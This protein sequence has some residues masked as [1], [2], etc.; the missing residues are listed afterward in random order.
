MNA[1]LPLPPTLAATGFTIASARSLGIGEKRLRGRDLQAPFWGVRSL[2]SEATPRSLAQAYAVRMPIG[3]FFSHVTAAELHGIPL[4]RSLEARLAVDVS[5]TVGRAMPTGRRVIGHRLHIDPRDLVLVDGMPVTSRARTWCDL[6][7]ALP[8]EDLIAAGDFLLWWR[9]PPPIYL[10]ASE[11]VEMVE[12][13]PGRRSHGVLTECVMS[14]SDRADSPPE[15]KMRRRFCL[16]GAPEPDVNIPV[17]DDTG[18]FVGQPDLS[19][20]RYRVAFDY[21]GDHHRANRVQWGKDL[22]RAPRFEDAAWSYLR[23]GAPDLTDS[24]RIISL[25]FRRLSSGGYRR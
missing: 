7:T 2:G 3:R 23:A 18:A 13:H 10:N 15:S 8:A 9:H 21:E 19:Y 24:R 4:P 5:T 1:R 22:A 16:A 14:L 17:Y 12:R 25:L 6:A 20:P 11:L